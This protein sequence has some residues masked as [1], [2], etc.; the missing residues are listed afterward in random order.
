M[1]SKYK[2]TRCIIIGIIVGAT[3]L[4]VFSAIQKILAG[5]EIKLKGFI[6]PLLFGSGTGALTANL[7]YNLNSEKNKYK[8]LNQLYF[9]A[10]NLK[11]LILHN[12]N[13]EFRTPLNNI[14]G[15]IEVMVLENKFSKSD[16]EYRLI[17]KAVD[18]FTDKLD[19]V[20]KLADIYNEEILWNFQEIIVDKLL[21]KCIDELNYDKIENNIDIKYE[22]SDKKKLSIYNDYEKIKYILK[23]II[24]N[25]IKYN[26]PNE[27]I[28]ITVID[29]KFH[30][31]IKVRDFG[32]G[33][34]SEKINYL[35]NP[36]V[37]DNMNY[38]KS[39]KGIGVGLTIS[40]IYLDYIN[41]EISIRSQSNQGT[42]V[43]VVIPKK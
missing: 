1:L 16:E 40:K 3:I 11:S 25:A 38:N 18:E 32:K 33:F 41:G 36:F 9:A 30:I 31:Q 20:I 12:I 37:Q 15:M 34:E 8:D 14:T 5:Y 17:N 4:C 23:S 42:E 39:Y 22:N 19:A 24:D 10:N 29:K 26:N 7:F 21:G 27:R 2:K 35:L 43:D 28:L 13:H 6:V